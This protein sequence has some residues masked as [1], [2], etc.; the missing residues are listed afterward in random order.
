M[1][2]VH[3]RS[4]TVYNT[5]VIFVIL[6]ATYHVTSV[7]I[8]IDTIMDILIANKIPAKVFGLLCQT[9]GKFDGI[10]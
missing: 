5:I 4:D 7:S 8:N 1:Y 10:Q 2:L 3:K 6:F 9:E